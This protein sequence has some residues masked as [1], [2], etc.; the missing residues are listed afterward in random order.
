M[1]LS[2]IKKLFLMNLLFSNPPY[3]DILREKF[4]KKNK[5]K[6]IYTALFRNLILQ[7][8]LLTS[9][10]MGLFL[11]VDFTVAANRYKLNLVFFA[12][13][14]IINLSSIFFNLFYE[15]K[16]TPALNI[17]PISEKE[18]FITKYI[19]LLVFV[20]GIFITM[21][22]LNITTTIKLNGFNLLGIILI[23][24]YTFFLILLAFNITI[25][26]LSS[27]A[28]TKL[29]KKY[30]KTMNV[31]V[32]ISTLIL[33]FSYYAIINV[34]NNE[35]IPLSE[36]KGD[37]LFNIVHEPL[38][39]NS[40]ASIAIIITLSL[41]SILLINKFIVKSYFKD[42]LGYTENKNKKL[43][44][45]TNTNKNVDI[46][47]IFSKLTINSFADS[48]LISQNILGPLM[49]PLLSVGF[50]I[51]IRGHEYLQQNLTI[52]PTI[53]LLSFVM[54]IFTFSNASFPALSI[55]IDYKNF[56]YLKTLPMDLKKYVLN[57]IYI[58]IGLHLFIVSVIYIVYF[59][60]LK[61]SLFFLITGYIIFLISSIIISIYYFAKDFDN[62]FLGWNSVIQLIL[63]GS[64]NTKLWFMLFIYIFLA[65]GV[66]AGT[67]IFT[68]IFPH[69]WWLLSAIYLIIIFIISIISI[70]KLKNK[71][72]NAE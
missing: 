11:F 55:S 22:A 15:D 56:S 16:D 42:I 43:F 52:L 39:L 9:I 10:T 61:V 24:V 51:N 8:I 67:I 23:I 28:K 29:F 48:T 49:M 57:K 71:V 5:Q 37:F 36:Y 72:L 17:L 1:R 13:F 20:L 27:L 69:L 3:I 58:S 19:N 53:I 6:S 14:G 18:I 45:E 65:G 66:L 32:T 46:N 50:I 62:P 31:I 21:F 60:I 47:K 38:S 26:F 12:I 63:R 64:S 4:K 30:R 68:N 25:L 35:I 40:L 34:I 59:L 41:L 7:Q 2:V 33:A 70:K 54:A 44:K